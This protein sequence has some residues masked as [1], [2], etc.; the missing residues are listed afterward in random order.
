MTVPVSKENLFKDRLEESDVEVPGV[1]TIRVRALS[2]SEVLAVQ[3][4]GRTGKV[5]PAAI[6]RKMLAYALV[7]PELTE[8]EV[9]EWQQASAAGEIEAVTDEVVAL[10]GMEDMAKAAKAAYKEFEANPDAE[11]RLPAG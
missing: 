5:G 4:L 9:G 10:S 7:D 8:A 11:F 1:G 2:R 3:H 6:E